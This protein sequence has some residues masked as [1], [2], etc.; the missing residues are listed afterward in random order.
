MK[1]L[2][3][4]IFGGLSLALAVASFFFSRW[5]NR[6][7]KNFRRTFSPI[8]VFT[9]GIFISVVLLFVPIY[10]TAKEL[11]DLLGYVTPF[12]LSVHNAFRVFI[13]DGEFNII[14]NSLTDVD[15]VLAASFSLY[16]ALLYVTAP[17]LTFG[18]VLSLFKNLRDELRYAW[19]RIRPHYIMSELNARSVALAK[20]I[21]NKAREEK[22][23]IVIVFTDVFEHNEESEYELVAEVRE[24]NAICL[25]RD[26]RFLN[27]RGKKGKVEIFL[28][29]DDSSENISQAVKITNSLNEENAKQN[30][31]LF[32]FDKSPSSSYIMDS[33]KYDNLLEY[34]KKHNY[35][36][37]TFKL[38]RVDEI[39]Q[40]V[41]HTVPEM[42]IFK[43]ANSD[44]TIS[45]LL[46]GMGRYG[47]EFFKTLVWYGQFEGY[48]LEF[49]IVDKHTD[50]DDGRRDIESVLRRQCPEL[51][52]KN[53]I[54]KDGEAAYD[55][56]FFPGI[57]MKTADFNEL[58][59]YSGDDE[60][61]LML[62]KRLKRTTHAVVALGEDDTNIEVAVYLRS[63]FD[64]VN[65]VVLNKDRIRCEDEKPAIYSVVFDEQKAGVLQSDPGDTNNTEF[66]INH[67]GVPYHVYFI[68]S[69][70]SQYDYDS[71]YTPHIEAQA[72]SRHE[73]W[74]KLEKSIREQWEQSHMKYERFEYYRLSSMAGA[75]HRAE[76]ERSFPELFNCTGD[77]SKKCV[78]E[79]CIK[80]KRIEH[81]RWN[82][83]MRSLGYV[84]KDVRADRA[85]THRDLL[86]WSE[87]P[88]EERQKD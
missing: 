8:Q 3:F 23:K 32:L 61:R 79:N 5:T 67:S 40:L 19:H 37:K 7:R 4:A 54:S 31:K 56:M 15:T 20:S 69:L 68:G 41:W 60:E 28:I 65:G 14:T 44:K 9:F 75:L 81:M 84:Q 88:L 21:W 59:S 29:G 85:K 13:L 76:L 53:R 39:Q 63:I 16:A 46:V 36:E 42:E 58:L 71:I 86:A 72:E 70:S 49:N 48:K 82:A 64:R 2:L 22:K 52:E 74:E 77:K 34:A 35:S 18:N 26:V 83:Y 80:R 43:R 55:I 10:Y 57:D 51:L 1:S 47:T 62:A 66:L 50:G 30:V 87:L 25:K 27:I 38:R 17:I 6:K 78:C 45:I 11:G 33:I 24:L 12:L 73:E